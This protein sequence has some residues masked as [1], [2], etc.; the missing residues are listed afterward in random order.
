VDTLL[1]ELKLN[2]FASTN[3]R[4]SKIY[5]Q[6]TKQQYQQAKVECSCVLLVSGQLNARKFR[7]HCNTEIVVDSLQADGS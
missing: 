2:F 6:T 7:N 1:R 3:I 4:S 5:S